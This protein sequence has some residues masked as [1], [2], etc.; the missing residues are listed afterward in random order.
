MSAVPQISRL[1]ALKNILYA[2]DLAK[3]SQA[4][5]PHIRAIAGE[6]GSSVHVLHV[7]SPEPMLEIPL[8]VPPELDVDRRIAISNLKKL[9][10]TKPFADAKTNIIVER[11]HMGDV[12]KRVVERNAIDLIVVGT[13]GRRGLSKLLMG[14]VA[15]Q[16]F[17]ASP[18]PVLTIGP[19]CA[20][21]KAGVKL[22]T[23]MFATDFSANAQH[24]VEYALSFAQANRAQLGFVHAVPQI[25]HMVPSGADIA[26]DTRQICAEI[27]TEELTRSQEKMASLICSET[28]RGWR[29]EGIIEIGNPAEVIVSAAL[30]KRADLI[31]MGAHHADRST[32]ASHFPWATAS[33]VA[34]SAPCPVLTV[35]S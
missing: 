12:V 27:E 30:K 18:C 14:S 7:L 33:A 29:A 24:A 20:E 19:N 10:A 13:H 3:D 26:G 32:T 6:F 28:M 9:I 23:I 2:T 21:A 22:A 8:D 11:G 15:E 16:I 25:V 34:C 4:A 35:G 5:I 31:V 1:P 17:R